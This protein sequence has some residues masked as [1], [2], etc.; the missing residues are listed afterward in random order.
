MFCS[1]GISEIDF[2]GV[3]MPPGESQDRYRLW[4]SSTILRDREL[5]DASLIVQASANTSIAMLEVQLVCRLTLLLLGKES[6]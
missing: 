1:G 5:S 4:V 3:K 2:D 6:A